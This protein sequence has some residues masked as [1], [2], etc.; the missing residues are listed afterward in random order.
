M[1]K[2]KNKKISIEDNDF[3]KREAIVYNPIV[4]IVLRVVGLW[5]P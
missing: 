5:L 3:A 1:K 2:N 4:S